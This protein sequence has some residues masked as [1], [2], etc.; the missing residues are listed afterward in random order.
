MTNSIPEI[1]DTDCLLVVGSNT[2]E[3]HPLISRW[4]FQ[5]KQNGAY[6]IVVDP[7]KIQLS[8]R[9]C[10]FGLGSERM[11]RSSTGSC[12][13]Y[14]PTIFTIAH[15]WT[16]EPKASLSSRSIYKGGPRK[17]LRRFA[18]FLPRIFV[19]LRTCTPA[20]NDPPSVIRLE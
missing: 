15:L 17:K 14:S 6:L 5:A 10:T 2:T 1:A 7:R 16:G 19:E 8:M 4:M 11:W 13:L 3:A 12:T 20:P 9:I 18:V